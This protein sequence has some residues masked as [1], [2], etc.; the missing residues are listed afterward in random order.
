MQNLKISRAGLV[1]FALGVVEAGLF[2]V[3]LGLE[4]GHR[5]AGGDLGGFVEVLLGLLGKGS[6]AGVLELDAAQLGAGDEAPG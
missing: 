5:A 4:K 6:V 3:D 2:Q 1:Q